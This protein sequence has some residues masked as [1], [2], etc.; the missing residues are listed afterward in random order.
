M[1]EKPNA[2]ANIITFLGKFMQIQ[3]PTMTQ[4]I[5]LTYYNQQSNGKLTETHDEH[6]I[7]D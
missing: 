2:S 3:S 5:H 6:F 1:P 7:L 4:H